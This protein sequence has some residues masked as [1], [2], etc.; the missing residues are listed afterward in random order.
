MTQTW[1]SQDQYYRSLDKKEDEEPKDG[2][3]PWERTAKAMREFKPKTRK[4]QFMDWNATLLDIFGYYVVDNSRP[5][6]Y[7]KALPC[8]TYQRLLNQYGVHELLQLPWYYSGM[9]MMKLCPPDVLEE[10]FGMKWAWNEKN[11]CEACPERPMCF[12]QRGMYT[13]KL[14]AAREGFM[15]GTAD[16]IDCL[17]DHIPEDSSNKDNQFGPES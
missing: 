7:R 2:L 6:G 3:T 13:P 10:E 11:E 12:D 14:Q 4:E 1:V 9:L 15:H 16:L 8:I 5:R 17:P